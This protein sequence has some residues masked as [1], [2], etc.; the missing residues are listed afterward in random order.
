MTAYT[1]LRETAD[2]CEEMKYLIKG[3]DYCVD[4]CGIID[5]FSPVD[6]MTKGQ[7]LSHL[8]W[9]ST[10]WWP[11]LRATLITQTLNLREQS[12][13]LETSVLSPD[14]FP[15]LARHLKETGQTLDQMCPPSRESNLKKAGL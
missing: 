6:M 11:R 7:S 5:I 12:G 4:L 13:N 8:L 15:K 1:E 9:S 10:K 3:Q 2:D 14:L